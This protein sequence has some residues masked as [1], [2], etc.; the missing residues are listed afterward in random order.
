MRILG[1][2]ELLSS[3]QSMTFAAVELLIDFYFPP[4]RKNDKIFVIEGGLLR[5]RPRPQRRFRRPRLARTLTIILQDSFA[6]DGDEVSTGAVE[7]GVKTRWN[8]TP[9]AVWRLHFNH[10]SSSPRGDHDTRLIARVR[11]PPIDR[12]DASI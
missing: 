6:A 5:G 4:G 3:F 12:Q 7:G 8:P 9:S 2:K 10:G 1:Y 11:H